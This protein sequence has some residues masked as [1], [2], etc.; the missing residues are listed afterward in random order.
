MILSYHPC[1]EA[2]R[3]LLCAGRE[4]DETDA[5][6]IS[7]ADAVIL[8]QG[9]YEALYQMAR[10]RG[11]RVFPNYDARFDYPGKIGQT[12][13][14]RQHG[15]P[16]PRTETYENLDAYGARDLR[17]CTFPAVFKFDWGGE[18]ET[19]FLVKNREALDQCL[20]RAKDFER[21]GQKGFLIQEYVPHACRSLRV[22]VVH[23]HLTAYWRVQADN[24]RFGTSVAAGAGIDSGSDPELQALAMARVQ[25][26]CK[27]TG[28]NLAGFDL[29]V[30]EPPR[31]PEPLFLEVNYFFGRRGLGGADAYYALLGR[32]VR[33][34]ISE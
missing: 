2:D 33:N 5:G 18:G 27:K 32:E 13:L 24:T 17:E 16:H 8:N 4:P 29:L 12:R 25:A 9:C 28:I 19:V 30:P 34:W 10:K 6:A 3:N 22:V 1:I 23:R 21:T 11:K 15:A 20:N 26:L 7:A 14:F 31:P